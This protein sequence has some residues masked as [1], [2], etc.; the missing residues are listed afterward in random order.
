MNMA[1]GTVTGIVREGHYRVALVN[2]RTGLT[3]TVVAA[4]FTQVVD[5]ANPTGRVL[6]DDDVV[7]VLT[8]DS[9]SFIV[10]AQA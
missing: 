5:A 2:G 1:I 7:L 10:G 4:S 6:E 3:Y 8:Q 9:A